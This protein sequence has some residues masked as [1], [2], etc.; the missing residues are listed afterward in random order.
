MKKR[1]KKGEQLVYDETT[2]LFTVEKIP[3]NKFKIFLEKNK[4]YFET[5]MMLII[6]IA[7]IIV[8]VVGVRVDV[9]ANNI[10]L[11]EKRIE[12]LEKQPSFVCD[13]VA[14]ENEVKYI[15]KNIGGDIKY[16]HAVC[17]EV[18]IITVYNENYDYIGKGYIILG[19]Y[20]EKDFSVYDF[21]MN[22]FD[23]SIDLEPKNVQELIERIDSVIKNEGFYCGFECTEYFN[24]TYTDYKRDDIERNM[25]LKGGKFCDVE[26]SENYEF[27]FRVNLENLENE[28][29]D[30]RIKQELELLEK[31]N[32]DYTLGDIL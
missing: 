9:A 14:D 20:F 25:F 18:L 31:F 17:D 19:N 12:D 1:S 13:V 26:E 29:I 32:K 4:I 27:L 24:F 11:E 7:G 2:K 21:E 30:S 22:C 8:S 3:D 5:I 28:N 23:F 10:S 16:G 15:V 6:S